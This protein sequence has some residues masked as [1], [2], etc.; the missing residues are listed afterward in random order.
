[1]LPDKQ[2]LHEFKPPLWLSV[3]MMTF[4]M[5]IGVLDISMFRCLFSQ[6]A[7]IM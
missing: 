1:M 2:F 3:C 7:S 4:R 6:T 5:V